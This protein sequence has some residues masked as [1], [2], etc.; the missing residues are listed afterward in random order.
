MPPVGDDYRASAHPPGHAGPF[1]T[2]N[3]VES[4]SIPI[5]DGVAK[6]RVWKSTEGSGTYCAKTYDNWGGSYS[7]EVR[8]WHAG[9]AT[10]WYDRG[11]Y[12]TYVGGIYVSDANHYCAYVSGWVK[13]DGTRYSGAD[14]V[15]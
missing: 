6:I 1:S 10:D 2:C 12:S 13:V 15:C 11:V 8:V 7:M 3:G 5:S 4:S 14:W 9:W